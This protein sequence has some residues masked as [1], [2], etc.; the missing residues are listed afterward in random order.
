MKEIMSRIN[1]CSL[2][3]L[4][5]FS[6]SYGQGPPVEDADFLEKQKTVLRN[7]HPHIF[8]V[9]EIKDVKKI[10]QDHTKVMYTTDGVYHEAIINSGRKDMLLIETARELKQEEVPEI[11]KDALKKNSEYKDATISR[12]FEV[13]RP[14]GERL[15]RLDIS[16]GKAKETIKEATKRTANEK[17]ETVYFNRLGHMDKGPL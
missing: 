1:S 17:T 2:V 14:G 4:L 3:I 13:S 8:E 12:A 15:F 7:T 10:D 16:R 6:Y 9:A 11:V 5:F